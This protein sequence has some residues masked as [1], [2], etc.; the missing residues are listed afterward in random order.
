MQDPGTLNKR[1]THHPSIN[2]TPVFATLHWLPASPRI[3]FKVRLVVYKA[4][5]GLGSAYITDSLSSHV[6]SQALRSSTASFSGY[7]KP[8]QKG[9]CRCSLFSS[10]APKLWKQPTQRY[11]R[12][13]LCRNFYFTWSLALSTFYAFERLLISWSSTFTVNFTSTFT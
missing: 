3:D 9:N 10:Y 5:N 11:F 6:P 2:I 1:E 4:L 8:H 7:S 12:R 13:R